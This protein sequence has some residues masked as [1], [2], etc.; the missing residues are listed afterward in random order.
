[1]KTGETR[2][3]VLPGG[4]LP[5]SLVTRFVPGVNCEVTSEVVH[6]VGFLDK[7]RFEQMR[8]VL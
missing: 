5:L 2:G 8:M 4:Q 3:E 7:K 1:M 6:S